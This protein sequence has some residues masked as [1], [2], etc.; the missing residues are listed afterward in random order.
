[1]SE[2]MTSVNKNQSIRLNVEFSKKN[3]IGLDF[4]SK[5]QIVVEKLIFK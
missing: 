5:F 2:K 3:D 4:I 1:M